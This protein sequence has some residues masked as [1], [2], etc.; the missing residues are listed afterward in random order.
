VA[1]DERLQGWVEAFGIRAVRSAKLAIDDLIAP[2]H[3][4][5][6]P[7]NVSDAERDRASTA[8]NALTVNQTSLLQNRWWSISRS[9]GA[10][11]CRKWKIRCPLVALIDTKVS[12][13]LSSNRFSFTLR[14]R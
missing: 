8:I 3:N 5:Y 13:T 4:G 9:R 10:K 12:T 7:F 2:H 14:G 1:T 11:R 6:T